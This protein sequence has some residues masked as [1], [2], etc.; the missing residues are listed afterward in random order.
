MKNIFL[1]LFIPL[2]ITDCFAQDT[3]ERKNKLSNHVIE[4]YYVLKA[5]PETKE[6]PYTALFRRKTLLARGNYHKNLKTGVW[7]FFNTNGTLIQ[8]YNYDKN[9]FTFLAPLNENDD[10]RFLFDDT[11]KNGDRV[12]IP[13]KIGGSYYGFIPYV[14]LF[15]L[16]FETWDIQTDAFEASIELLI[17]PMGRLA[18]YTVHIQSGF[19]DYDHTFKLDINLFDEA[20]RTFKPAALNGTPV[21]SRIII[22]CFVTSEGGLDFN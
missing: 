13:L 9:I 18:D 17:S 20:D 8:K 7:Q 11:L 10:L 5:D 3:A 4:R 2:C 22:K 12:A 1:L 6:G 15:R 14:S 16:P 21:L 19:Y